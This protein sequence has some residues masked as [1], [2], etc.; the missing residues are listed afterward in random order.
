MKRFNRKINDFSIKILLLWKIKKSKIFL[1]Y[2]ETNYIDQVEK[3]LKNIL[4]VKQYRKRKEFYQ[5][6]LD[7]HK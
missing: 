2:N 3:C 6:Y 1:F 5:I 4:S 7:I